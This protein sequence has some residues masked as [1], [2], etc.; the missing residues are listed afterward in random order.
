MVT[1]G[2][3]QALPLLW[4]AYEPLLGTTTTTAG[5]RTI[6]PFC[7]CAYPGNIWDHLHMLLPDL[8]LPLLLRAYGPL[9]ETTT[10]IADICT[11]L[12]PLL[13]S[14]AFEPLLRAIIITA[15]KRAIPTLSGSAYPG[16]ILDSQT[17][18]R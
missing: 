1:N 16:N 5:I 11:P 8:A 17:A 18:F 3:N 6:P 13:L 9:V 12:A 2:L 4:L 15:D 7:G 10:I 14:L